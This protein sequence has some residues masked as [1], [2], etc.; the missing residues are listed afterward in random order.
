MHL[1]PESIPPRR[2]WLSFQK[3]PEIFLYIF[4]SFFRGTGAETKGDFG[5]GLT[6][7]KAIVEGH[8]G[9]VLVGS[10]LGTGSVFTVVLPKAQRSKDGNTNAEERHQSP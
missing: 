8:G 2:R 9:R 6:V 3:I 4:D 10:E 7:V 1:F 5:L